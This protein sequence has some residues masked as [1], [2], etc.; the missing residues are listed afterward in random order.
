MNREIRIVIADDHPLIRTG[1][2]IEIEKVP[3]L[4]IV[5]EAEDGIEALDQ[6]QALL[7]EV[8]I[9]DVKMPN[10]SGFDVMQ[11]IQAKKLP[12][13]VIILT[14]HKDERFLNAA[15]DKGAKGYVLK[16]SATTE[17]IAAIKAVAAGE[18][19]VSP[20]LSTHL[21]NQ[22]KQS[23]SLAK[24]LPGLSDLTPTEL[25]V[26]RLIADKK[27]SREIADEMYISEHTVNKHRENISRKLDLHGQH[28]LHDFAIEHKAELS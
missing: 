18:N 23:I 17:I 22:R 3:G 19:Y 7:P 12:V 14:V 6:I 2:R 13:A 26:L 10:L 11:A 24:Q 27:T 9:L 5:A 21:V 15:L 20:A 25:R 16:E 28:T 4:I 1:L 8:A